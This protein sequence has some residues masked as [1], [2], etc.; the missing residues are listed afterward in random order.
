MQRF[1]R[2]NLSQDSFSPPSRPSASASAASEGM[3]GPPEGSLD[4][5]V[6]RQFGMSGEN[7]S[8]QS[9]RGKTPLKRHASETVFSRLSA[10]SAMSQSE[11]QLSYKGVLKKSRIQSS[12]FDSDSVVPSPLK[13]PLWPYTEGVLAHENIHKVS[14]KNRLGN[15][16]MKS[17]APVHSR[18]GRTSNPI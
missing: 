11:D 18:L 5:K 14:V 2:L 16:S 9:A 13:S 6:V 10:P 1:I 7:S 17:N 8:Q 15:R 3:F 12:S 4:F